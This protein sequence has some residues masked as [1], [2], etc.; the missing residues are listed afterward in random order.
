[1]QDQSII[2]E[3]QA[4]VAAYVALLPDIAA[5]QAHGQHVFVVACLGA[6]ARRR[7]ADHIDGQRT[8][9]QIAAAAHVDPMALRR[10]LRFLEPHGV[11]ERVDGRISLA[12]KGRLLRSDSPLWSSLALRGANDAVSHLDHS[13]STGEAAFPEV[14]GAEFWSF[15]AAHPDQQD[16]FADAMRLQSA[17]LSVA[18]IPAMD[19]SAVTTIA[20]V[21]GGTGDLLAAILETNSRLR[22]VLFDRPEMLARAHPA[23]RSG[24]VAARVTLQPGDLLGELPR[25]DAYVLS[26]VV[27]DWDDQGVRHILRNLRRAAPSSARLFV[28]TMLVPENAAPH[29]SKTSDIGMM[30]LFGGGRERTETELRD[31]LA[32]A[33]WRITTVTPTRVADILVATATEPASGK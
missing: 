5:L 16:A 32:S 7:I 19:L 25:A 20:D 4:R 10:I 2:K 24:P 6:L 9:D 3:H 23:L 18:C 29:P 8:P 27:H 28:L 11:F 17:M 1:M 14:F 26:Q 22:G 31:L 33:G 30:A 13:L 12:A 21:G 15:L